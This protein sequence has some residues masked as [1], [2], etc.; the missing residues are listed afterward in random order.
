MENKQHKY[1]EYVIIGKDQK[2]TH[3]PNNI[4]K[5]IQ[6]HQQRTVKHRYIA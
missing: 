1:T 2:T 3:S 4:T 6:N 5:Y